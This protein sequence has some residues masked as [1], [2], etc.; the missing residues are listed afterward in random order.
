MRFITNNISI[1]R[2]EGWGVGNETSRS[3]DRAV[4]IWYRSGRPDV[5][6]NLDILVVW[7]SG[8]RCTTGSDDDVLESYI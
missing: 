4:D 3:V 7:S 8:G 2:W 6:S 5:W 1:G